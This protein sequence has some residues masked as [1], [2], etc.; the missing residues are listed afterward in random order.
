MLCW[1]VAAP[2]F[3][4]LLEPVQLVN[5]VQQ[6]QNLALFRQENLVGC[7]EFGKIAT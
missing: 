5:F 3:R 2:Q 6:L 4:L 1:V 7:E